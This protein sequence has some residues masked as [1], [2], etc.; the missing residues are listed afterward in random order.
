MIGL[1]GAL[2]ARGHE[3]TLQTWRRWK[4]DVRANGMAFAPAP[5][6]HV[7][8]TRERPLAPYEAVVRATRSTRALVAALRPDAVVSD[9]L[10]LAPALAGELAGVPVATFVPHLDPRTER[11]W[12]PYSLGARVAR[13]GLGAGFWGALGRVADA[14]LQRGRRELNETRRRLGLPELARV[15]G[16]IS[17]SLALIGTFPQLEYPRHAALPATHVVGPLMWEPPYGEVQPPPGDEPLVLVAPSTSQDPAGT[18]LGAT[19][20]GLG[21]MRVRVLA[22]WNRP[23]PVAI[24]ANARLVDWVSYSRTMPRCDVVVCHGG[25]GTVARALHSGCVVVT[26]PAAGDMNENAARLDWAGL[27]VRVPRRLCGPRA[28]GLA[29]ARAL[30]EPRLRAG[31]EEVAAWSA[32][33]DGAATAAGLVEAFARGDSVREAN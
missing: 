8:P 22:S 32:S 16:G 27:G 24:P 10:T 31:V 17:T 33:H 15:H 23:P 28:V 2:A 12:P 3:V 9:I 1:G 25:H 26:V 6:Y 21:R 14:G 7:F 4:G 19:L 11:G 20:T 29:V 13:T 30:G 5:E 18:L